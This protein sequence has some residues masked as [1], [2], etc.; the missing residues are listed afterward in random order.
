MNIS[1]TDIAL[2]V[3][4][5]CKYYDGIKA[6]DS[7]SLQVSRGELFGLIG[8]DSAGKTT[9]MRLALGLIKADS[10]DIRIFGFDP[11]RQAMRVKE[12]TGYISQR[13]SLY[14]DLSIA[15]N[16]RFFAELYLVPASL[17]RQREEELMQF[18]RLGPFR[19]RRAG[20]LS[21]GMK[22]KL[23]LCCTLIHTPQLII[24]DE[25]TTGV[26]PVSRR[27]FWDILHKLKSDGISILISTPYM[28]EAQQCDRVALMHSGKIFADAKPDQLPALFQG[29]LLEI[30]GADLLA[31]RKQLTASGIS[32]RQI[33]YLSDR[34]R[35]IIPSKDEEEQVKSILGTDKWSV[36]LAVPSIEDTFVER[37]SRG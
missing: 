5:L 17:R 31:A 2:S 33:H 7:V 35:L 4:R 8:P 11:Q 18:S 21:G 25:P 16:L 29:I 30:T 1:N 10:G 12:L 9:L 19:Q 36:R 28:D 37:I 15:E 23:A 3:A 27:E 22:Q 24:L 20:Q 32:P 13:F 6:L 34:L 14:P 26:D